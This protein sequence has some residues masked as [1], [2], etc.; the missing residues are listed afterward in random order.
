MVKGGLRT[1]TGLVGKRGNQNAYRIG[2]A[3]ATIGIRGS[4]GDTIVCAPS[5]EGVVKGG[6]KLPPGTHH[7]TH[8][9]IY[10]MEAG[11]KIV[12]IEEGHSGHA[13]VSGVITVIKGPIGGGI[14]DLRVPSGQGLKGG[15]CK[16]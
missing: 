7:H 6:D 16:L 8:S 15:G 10:S 5:C 12:I 1:V 14:L 4:I 3:T 11:G 13:N 2:T 9:G